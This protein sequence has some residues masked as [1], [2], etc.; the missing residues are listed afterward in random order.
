MTPVSQTLHVTSAARHSGDLQIQSGKAVKTIFFDHGR[1]VF[2]ASNLRK[3]R[4]GESLVATGRITDAQYKQAGALLQGGKRARIG[5]A[6]VQAGVLQKDEIGRSVARQVKR[7]VLSTFSFTE[8]VTSFEERRS[9]IPLEYMVSLSLHQIL[10]EGIRTMKSESLVLA[11][12]GDL[13]RRVKLASVPPFAF[14]LEGCTDTEREILEHA[15]RRV[16]VRRLGWMPGGVAFERLRATYALLASGVLLEADADE[17]APQ[18]II[19]METGT[20][21]LSTLQRRPDP[22]AAEAIRQEVKQELER[23]ARLDRESWLKVSREAPREELERALEEKMERYHALLDASA[24]DTGLKTDLEV[25]LG[26]ASAMLRL[27]R[28]TPAPEPVPREEPS[29]APTVPAASAVAAPVRESPVAAKTSP[30][31]ERLGDTPA[32]FKAHL[33]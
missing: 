1:I 7:I 27:A 23:S 11:G 25:I 2:A 33:P 30:P 8:G 10:F 18:P 12:L 20:F 6:L 31:D 16:T 4:L 22:T 9:P 21:L 28:Q 13:D 32:P 26:R 15:Q 5:D 3:D 29:P 14:S 24:S 17:A 19:Q